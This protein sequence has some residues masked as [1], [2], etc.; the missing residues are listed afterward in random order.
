MA[1]RDGYGVLRY[2]RRRRHM[3]ATKIAEFNTRVQQQIP[4]HVVKFRNFWCAWL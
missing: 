1:T 4:A 2:L 3:E